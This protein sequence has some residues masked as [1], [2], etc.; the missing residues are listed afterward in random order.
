MKIGLDL[1]NVI[2][3]IMAS[4][5]AVMAKDHSLELEEVIETHVYWE[6]FT[7]SDPLIAETLKPDHSFWNR[8][9]VL[10][11]APPLPGSLE[12]VLALH[13]AGL[14]ACYITRRPPLVDAITRQWLSMH[15]FPEMPVVHVGHTDRDQYFDRC[16]STACHEHGVTHMVDDQPHEIESLRAA[17]IN[18]ILVDAPVGRAKRIE[19]LAQNPSIPVV[20]T[21]LEATTMLLEERAAA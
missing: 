6:P 17:G 11:G 14:L 4:A 5:R 21:L 13:E 10:L 15:S 16:K 19:F 3:D 2:V 12:A 1:D 18:T 8:E 7:H 9:D 20:A